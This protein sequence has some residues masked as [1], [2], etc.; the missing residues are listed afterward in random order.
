M[1]EFKEIDIKDYKTYYEY[2]KNSGEL[3]CENSFLNMLI[4]QCGYHN[5]NF[6]AICDN[7]LIIKNGEGERESFRL[8]MGDDFEKGMKLIEEYSGDKK[9]RFW[10][11]EGPRYEL[12]KEYAK[13][14]TF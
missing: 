8:P 6:L 11:Q 3:S 5:K 12:F 10:A 4:W 2:Y 13:G 9:P 7:Q 1:L 14:Y